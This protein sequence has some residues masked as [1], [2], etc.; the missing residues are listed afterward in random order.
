MTR[1]SKVDLKVKYVNIICTQSQP[2]NDFKKG[3]GKE[4]MSVQIYT[5]Y[6]QNIQFYFYT[7]FQ[8]QR[9]SKIMTALKSLC[10]WFGLR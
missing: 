10:Q 9:V 3:K 1:L 7:L 6:I 2:T 8:F 4:Y 5:K